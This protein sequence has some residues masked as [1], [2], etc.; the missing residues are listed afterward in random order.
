M[1]NT[2]K[3]LTTRAKAIVR[4]NKQS[5]E[6]LHTFLCDA[7]ETAENN[8]HNFTPIM[9]VL[10]GVQGL[11][12]RQ[13]LAWLKTYAPIYSKTDKDGGIVLKLSKSDN[14][15]PYD[16]D[17]ARDNPFYNMD[18]PESE[19]PSY[20]LEKSIDN[21]AKRLVK[22]VILTSEERAKVHAE[23]DA[24]INAALATKKAKKAKTEKSVK[25]VK[26]AA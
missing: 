26:Q 3:S 11:N 1:S 16:V 23:L 17:L 6:N 14:A 4:G 25:T 15:P 22:N 18:K 13:I 8:S 20:D 24:A 12:N 10:N 2:I 21:F 19:A 5:M 7:L 9:L